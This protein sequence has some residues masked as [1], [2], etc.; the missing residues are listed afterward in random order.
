MRPTGVECR[1]RQSI[2]PLY[3]PEVVRLL[4]SLLR[5][6]I[7][8]SSA[9]VRYKLVTPNRA[10][11]TCLIALRMESPFEEVYLFS[12]LRLLLCYSYHQAGS[13]Q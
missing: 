13:W 6:L 8:N 10:D 11:A 4:V 5:H 3:V 2:H 12:L 1:T 7:C 9:S